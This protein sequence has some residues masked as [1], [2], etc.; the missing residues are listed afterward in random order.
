[1]P[2]LVLDKVLFSKVDDAVSIE[3]TANDLYIKHAEENNNRVRL[4]LNEYAE[5]YE[6]ASKYFVK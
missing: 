2:T 5:A 3:R 4:I 1:M 6:N